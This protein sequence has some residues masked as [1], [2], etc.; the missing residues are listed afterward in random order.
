VERLVVYEAVAL[1]P[2]SLPDL[3]A[4]ADGVLLYSPRTARLWVQAVSNAQIHDLRH[5]CLSPNV[6]AQL[7]QSAPIWVAEKPDESGM[8]ALLD[9]K[10][11]AE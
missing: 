9:R 10:A 7:P 2:V 3:I 8:L 4:F 11:E 1:D 6:A 5:F